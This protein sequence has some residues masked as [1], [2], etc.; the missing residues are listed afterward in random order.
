MEKTRP[1]TITVASIVF[2]VF[3]VLSIIAAIL[4]GLEASAL[5]NL[6]EFSAAILAVV[7]FLVALIG[8]VQIV[9]GYGL[10]YMKRWASILGMLLSIFGV[11]VQS[12]FGSISAYPLYY[13]GNSLLGGYITSGGTWVNILLLILI[14][15]SW[16]S[17]EPTPASP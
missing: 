14:A 4:V 2:I 1:V 8:F 9:A 6:S 15:I 5:T 17:F 7:I 12:V 10:W 3:G 13:T 11:M 16:K